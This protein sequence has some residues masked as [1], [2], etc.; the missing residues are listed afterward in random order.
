[1]K[2]ASGSNL[3]V[4]RSVE[5]ALALLE[6]VVSGHGVSLTDAAR[7]VDVPTSTAL[8][9]LKALEIDG[10]ISRAGDATFEAGPRFVR[11]A[12]VALDHAPVARLAQLAKPL[13]VELEESTE[14]SAYLAVP[15]GEEHAVYVASQESRRAIRHVSWLGTRIPRHGTAV[16]ETLS[17]AVPIGHAVARTGAVEPDVTSVASPVWGPGGVVGALA[18]IGPAGRLTGAALERASRAVAK[19]AASMSTKE[20]RR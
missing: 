19:L 3:H 4:A 9:H 8:R 20:A 11:L 10:F 18:V 1:M 7:A 15:E 14:E 6:V 2:Q 17:G 16:G 5:R 13:L 12:L